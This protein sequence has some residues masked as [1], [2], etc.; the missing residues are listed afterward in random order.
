M[1][2][3]RKVLFYLKNPPAERWF[4]ARVEGA[5]FE[6][7][8]EW[9]PDA[10][11]VVGRSPAGGV[12]DPAR[13][14]EELLSRGS[15]PVCLVVAAP[16]AE[17]ERRL[18]LLGVP[19]ECVVWAN[20]V[21]V[22]PSEVLKKLEEAI[23]KDLR[24]E[25][26]VFAPGK[27]EEPAL[28][29]PETPNLPDLPEPAEKKAE[30]LEFLGKV[31]QTEAPADWSALSP[32]KDRIIVVT[33]A[34]T[35]IGRTTLAASLAAHFASLEENV[36]AVDLDPSPELALHL[37]RPQLF[38]VK[39]E[40]LERW[41]RGRSKHGELYVPDGASPLDAFVLLGV[42]SS[43]GK[44][45]VVD[46]PLDLAPWGDFARVI[47]VVGSDLRSLQAS[48]DRL[49]RGAVV[50]ASRVQPADVN[51]WPEVVED[52]LGAKPSIVLPEDSEGCRAAG[53]RFAPAVGSPGSTLLAQAVGDLVP[54]IL[55]K[56]AEVR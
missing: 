29:A 56:G 53:A 39:E 17:L 50:V 54:L 28:F 3:G 19:G 1:L 26:V 21:G 24:P 37:E 2:A 27:E 45:V 23:E 47:F 9:D 20:G 11:V 4:A 38:A 6:L 12:D 33:G 7:S 10:A 52:A 8:D 14:V 31:S 18:K 25:P 46:A 36:A 34:G 30:P 32:F 51:V 42:L 40:G 16:D 49:P 43:Q 44:R 5:R 55:Q 35:G 15:C 13:V 41:K 22:R 48:K